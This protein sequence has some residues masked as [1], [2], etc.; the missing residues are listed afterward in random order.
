[1]VGMATRRPQR[2]FSDPGPGNHPNFGCRSCLPSLAY[3]RMA[4]LIIGT[5]TV[6]LCNSSACVA[7][8]GQIFVDD[9]EILAAVT[10]GSMLFNIC[11][12]STSYG[13]ASGL[14][15]L[16]SQ[17][18][19]A[20]QAEKQRREHSW[21][22]AA[23]DNAPPHPGRAHV[24]WTV[25]LLIL[26]WVPLGTLC[27]F[28]S[29]VLKAVGQ[30]AGV[31]ERAGRF[32]Q[33]LT[34]SAGVPLVCRTVQGKIINS[35]RIT[36][37]P[38]LGS[39]AG[40]LAHALFLYALYSGLD[41]DLPA[42]SSGSAGID[43]AAG[44]SGSAL[45][46]KIN[47]LL[48]WSHDDAYLGAALGRAVY[49]VTSTVVTGLYLVLSRNA[50]CPT[51]CCVSCGGGSGGGGK[52]AS[53]SSLGGIH[54]GR[55]R[56]QRF[57]SIRSDSTELDTPLTSPVMDDRIDVTASPIHSNSATSSA[58]SSS[59]SPP[60][61]GRDHAAGLCVVASLAIP[62]MLSMVAE[63][64]AAEFRALIA[65]WVNAQGTTLAQFFHLCTSILPCIWVDMGLLWFQPYLRLWRQTA[66]CSCSQSC[67]TRSRKAWELRRPSAAAMPSAPVRPL[68]R[69]VRRSRGSSRLGSLQWPAL[70]CTKLSP[71]KLY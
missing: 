62:S 22:G 68:R 36:W 13:M 37:P 50:I 41:T 24:R 9:P 47:P 17:A 28:S 20:V 25:L 18:H 31:S 43:A 16:L 49:A 53:S 6:D 21:P 14:D 23:H 52:S 69:G 63:W 56:R 27:I 59:S 65:G 15:T 4:V 44:S 54:V 26:V 67:S 1:M 64:W 29:P 70:R 61:R 32:A 3:L 11:L 10:V 40:S 60:G 71:R 57:D 42:D 19:G 45:F 66:W 7:V 39:L 46:D 48:G 33:V 34:V 5:M 8:A 58:S 2:T 35:A 12:L 51:G 38:L 55:D 30:P